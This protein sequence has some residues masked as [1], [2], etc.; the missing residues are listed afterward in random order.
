MV[1]K[2][3]PPKRVAPTICRP[4]H[5]SPT[6]VTLQPRPYE[7]VVFP[8]GILAGRMALQYNVEV[9]TDTSHIMLPSAVLDTYEET[10]VDSSPQEEPCHI[11]YPQRWS[12]LY[13]SK[14]SFFI[15]KLT[16]L[17][18][19]P[20]ETRRWIR[21][22]S[23]ERAAQEGMR[24]SEE[25]GQYVVNWVQNHCVLYEGSRA[26]E[27]IDIDD[28]QYEFFMQLFGWLVQNE[29][30]AERRKL[31]TCWI[32][33]FTQASIWIAK[34][35]AK[36][37]ALDT[38]IPTVTGWKQMRDI[39]V[40]DIIFDESGQQTKVLSCSEVFTDKECFNVEFSDG[41]NI[42]ASEDHLW[43]VESNTDHYESSIK[44]TRQL[45]QKVKLSRLNGITWANNHRIPICQSLQISDTLLSIP[46]YVLGVWLCDG[47]SDQFRITLNAAEWE[48]LDYTREL[49]YQPLSIA[50]KKDTNNYRVNIGSRA[51]LK[52]LGVLFDKHIPIN[53]LRS[54]AEQRLE[55][56][57]GLMDTDG[58]I[59]KAGQCSFNTTLEE[60]ASNV[61]E[62]LCSLGFKPTL[63]IDI[64]QCN[65]KKYGPSYR[66]QFWPNVSV[67]KLKRKVFRQRLTTK[68]RT[69]RS[70]N[71]HII[72]ITSVGIVPCKCIKVD[73]PTQMFLAGQSMIPTH[74]SPTLAATGLYTLCGDGEKGNKCYSVA[75]DGNQALISHTHA[76]MM[77]EYSPELSSV[78]TIKKTNY[79]IT[80]NP[81]NSVYT[82]VHG[83]NAKSTEGYNGS[84][85]VDETHVVDQNQID[86]LKRAGISR[87]EPLHV[88]MSTAGNNA[89]GYGY[90]RYHYGLRV[91]QMESSNDYTPQILFIDFSVNQ[92]VTLDQ[93][94]N[95]EFIERIGPECNPTMG[96]ILKK[97]EF[98]QDWHESVRSE[99]ELRKFAMYRL[100]LWLR[101]TASWV[102][103]QDWL[104]CAE[105]PLKDEIQENEN[106]DIPRQY[107]LEDLMEYPC[108]GGLDLSKVKD[109]TSLTLIFAVP[110]DK[111]GVRPYT[112]TWHWMPRVTAQAYS[113]YVDFFNPDY[114]PFLEFINQKTIDYDHVIN[115][116]EWVR[117]NFDIRALG[118]DV[119]NAT[120]LIRI[121]SV[122]KGWDEDILIKVP[123]TMKI[124]GPITQEVERWIIRKEV[125]HPNNSLLSWQFQHAALDMDRFGN[126]R[127]IKPE[128]G[129]YRKVDGIVSMLI[130][131]V[132]ISSDVCADIWAGRQ[133]ILL[134]RLQP[135]ARPGEITT[136]SVNSSP[137]EEPY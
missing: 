57:K 99:T 5:V 6:P 137:Q 106:N 39:Q 41:T 17:K 100:N 67:F 59:S 48:I 63:D 26:G 128:R 113:R 110:D 81:T 125:H 74:N 105:S 61:W 1:R 116:L 79:S 118:Y 76:M 69:A 21:N 29:E 42:V 96:R 114:E 129:D 86:R 34:K 75:R 132:T 77:V 25:R 109:M 85:F 126:Y 32:R 130:A 89:D 135:A 55:L 115:H 83:D 31:D 38:D 53:Y 35:N 97:S 111:L 98:M 60:L 9:P 45:S 127:V 23:D 33:R 10:A 91:S 27:Y 12:N 95:K 70:S 71:R 16:P 136:L 20:S 47:D 93:L 94:K 68:R 15:N 22:A 54:S 11:S 52:K 103:L 134:Y 24:V 121:L 123:Q 101:D 102:E 7:P 46:P 3:N 119:Y 124:M 122:T 64:A 90:N 50:R 104:E 92:K 78:C 108:V 51:S 112:W 30:L 107:T 19:V 14:Q 72:S 84:I 131:G 36:A 65:G 49:G 37:L 120:E 40:G 133:S 56:L 44:T 73:S 58:T 13:E 18:G 4:G 28:W 87:D 82:L 2:L 62:L 117:D 43:K 88:E 80:H 8:K 66:I